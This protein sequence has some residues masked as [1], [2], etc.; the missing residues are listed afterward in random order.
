MGSYTDLTV[1]GYPILESKSYVVHHMMTLFQES[2]KRVEVKKISQRNPLI[3]GEV[4]PDE[5]D[6]EEVEITYRCEVWK[7]ADRLDVMGFTIRR[8]RE[9]FEAAR[10]SELEKYTAWAEESESDWCRD[11]VEYFSGLTFDRYSEALRTVLGTR[12]RF[13]SD[14]ASIPDLDPIV[15]RIV[16]D[17]EEWNLGFLC[18]D[19]RSLV[20]LICELVPRDSEVVQDISE[21]VRAGYYEKDEAVCENS[22]RALT[23]GH[24]ENSSR[25][26]LTEGSTD[27]EILRESLAL[28]YPHLSGYYTFLDFAS[29]RSRGGA[30]SLVATIK[31][32]AAAGVSN[33]IV[34]LFDNDTAAFDARRSLD[35][36]RLPKNIAVCGC[37]DLIALESYPTLGPGGLVW[38][39]VNGLAASIELYMGSDLIGSGE[40][41]P[42]QWK[43]YVESL[44]KYQGEVMHKSRLQELF[45]EKIAR[46]RL[47]CDEIDLRDW[48][49]LRSIFKVI[50]QAF[51]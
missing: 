17:T 19:L 37:P 34:A 29:S 10:T 9:E 41:F 28:L 38:L 51:D 24:P 39:N 35:L 30:G 11:E 15:K 43:G 36:V 20:R 3:W 1:D 4:A 7:V 42:V 8:A 5:D 22:F 40:D 2:D 6:E 48:S 16:G 45:R 14:E 33:R 46:C 32:F 44:G 49:G 23:A 26:I 50:F 31:A 12:I 47:S 25:I 18:S 27:V 13:R 21:V